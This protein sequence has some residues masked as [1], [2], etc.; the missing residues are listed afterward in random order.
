MRIAL[1]CLLAAGC[2]QLW[3]LDHV[4]DPTDAAGDG[5]ADTGEDGKMPACPTA[6]TF[7]PATGT[8]YNVIASP[9]P[10]ANARTVCRSMVAG[11][12]WFTHLAVINTKAEYDIL[13]T[14]PRVQ[15]D[16]PWIGAFDADP[17]NLADE[18][19]WVTDDPDTTIVWG[20][21]QPDTLDVSHCGRMWVP[22]GMDNDG[23]DN[24]RTY[25][26]ECDTHPDI[27]P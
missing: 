7:Q 4:R 9:N 10:W 11:A 17:S 12:G 5:S 2:D 18:F 24:S 22:E 1:A 20:P 3:N 6:Y 26:C 23:C 14:L 19:R 15:N 13:M 21:S 25:I 16:G 27:E 8:S